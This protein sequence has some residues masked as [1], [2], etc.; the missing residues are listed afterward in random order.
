MADTMNPDEL[1]NMKASIDAMATSSVSVADTM[2]ATQESTKIIG[3]SLEGSNTALAAF[4]AT[5][6]EILATLTSLNEIQKAQTSTQDKLVKKEKEGLVLQKDLTWMQARRLKGIE[7]ELTKEKKFV[8]VAGQRVK[9]SKLE[10]SIKKKS[11][12][13]MKKSA[14]SASGFAKSTVAQVTGLSIGL[15]TI[16]G[17]LLKAYNNMRTL[18]GM[19][20]QASAHFSGGVKEIGSARAAV[21]QLR[22]GFAATYE[23]AGKV[24]TSLAQMGMSAEEIEGKHFKKKTWLISKTADVKKFTNM[25][26][27]A[28]RDQTAIRAKLSKEQETMTKGDFEHYTG[29]LKEREGDQRTSAKYLLAEAKE[30]ESAFEK[31][32]DKRRKGFKATYG[33]AQELYAIEKQYGIGVQQSGMF[34]KQMEQDYGKLNDEARVMLG[35]AIATATELDNIGV[36]ELVDDWSKLIGQARTY[37]TDVMGILALYNTMM[38]KEDEI[39]L[40]GV[41]ISVRKSIVSTVSAWKGAL[42]LGLKAKL[43]K[44]ETA[45]IRALEF[46]SIGYGEQLKRFMDFARTQAPEGIETGTKAQKARAN[47]RVRQIAEMYKF[48]PDVQ[49]FLADAV[50]E[51]KINNETTKQQ[52]KA[53][54]AEKEAIKE[55]EKLWNEQRGTLIT[56]AGKTS[57]YL[58]TIQ[59]L[60]QRKFEDF[61]NKYLNPILS[62]LGDIWSAISELWENPEENQ[63]KIETEKLIAKY[64]AGG[65]SYFMHEGMKKYGPGMETGHKTDALLTMIGRQNPDDSLLQLGGK[66]LTAGARDVLDMFGMPGGKSLTQAR[67]EYDNAMKWKMLGAAAADI[68]SDPKLGP[69]FAKAMERRNYKETMRILGEWDRASHVGDAVA[70]T[71]APVRSD[72]VKASGVSTAGGGATVQSTVTARK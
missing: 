45:P 70:G 54:E 71:V 32:E 42:D 53:Y 40:K 50:V 58:L 63:K 61:A 21:F 2:A 72:G 11:Y 17:L 55:N 7:Q 25:Q 30:Q 14:S 51:G 35:A 34:V 27:S 29:L 13:L 46:E 23:E 37:K 38:R 52:L 26:M 43:G 9:L 18:S 64:G 48:D 10:S 44:G 16:V 47:V 49:K 59:Q 22:R 8:E 66:G 36:A 28:A 4:A 68:A 31:A 15:G 12:G 62:W 33:A 6:K 5:S 41:P 60:L 56:E 57:Q 65:A 20:R 69:R 3:S 67:T 19:T 39:G 1:G 24:V